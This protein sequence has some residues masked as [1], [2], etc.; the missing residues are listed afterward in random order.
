[1]QDVFRNYIKTGRSIFIWP[2]VNRTQNLIFK[3]FKLLTLLWNDI[4][5]LTLFKSV[6]I[7]VSTIRPIKV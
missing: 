6:L 7:H 2:M 5:G 4:S 1:M 3:S